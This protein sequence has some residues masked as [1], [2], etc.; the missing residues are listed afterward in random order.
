MQGAQWG[1]PFASLL[2]EA[3]Q[4]DRGVE[5]SLPGIETCHGHVSTSRL[6]APGH[7]L[8]RISA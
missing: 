7:P 5:G 8:I 6:T 1:A 3:D 2:A 4:A